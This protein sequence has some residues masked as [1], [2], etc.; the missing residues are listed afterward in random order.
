[1]KNWIKFVICV[2]LATIC[3]DWAFDLIN[4]SSTIANLAGIA[5]LLVEAYVLVETKCFTDIKLKK[6]KKDEEVF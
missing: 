1:M 5:L 2:V 4:T 3:A 6:N